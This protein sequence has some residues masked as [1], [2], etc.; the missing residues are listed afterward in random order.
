MSMATG[1]RRQLFSPVLLKKGRTKRI[2]MTIGGAY[3]D[4]TVSMSS[5]IRAA[6]AKIH[7]NQTSG[8]G[9]V[10]ISDG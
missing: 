1:R 2:R 4:P 5:G 6:T 3:G 8:R 9:K 7:M 10:S